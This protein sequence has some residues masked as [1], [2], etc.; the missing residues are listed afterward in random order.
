MTSS[1]WYPRKDGNYSSWLP[2][3]NEKIDQY[4]KTPGSFENGVSV[5][6]NGA[7]K[8]LFGRL[9]SQSGVDSLTRAIETH[10]LPEYF[11]GKVGM[12]CYLVISLIAFI[13]S[14]VL[15]CSLFKCFRDKFLKCGGACN[16][17]PRYHPRHFAVKLKALK[18]T[19]ICVFC[20]MFA[21]SVVSLF[22]AANLSYGTN[23][24][25]CDF[26]SGM[27]GHYFG[28]R[29]FQAP[30]GVST[31]W[32]GSNPQWVVMNQL[33]HIV[34]PKPEGARPLQFVPDDDKAT[35]TLPV[36]PLCQ[37]IIHEF[38]GTGGFVEAVDNNRKTVMKQSIEGA[39]LDE[40]MAWF[41]KSYQWPKLD[42]KNTVEF[43]F[44]RVEEMKFQYGSILPALLKKYAVDLDAT[45]DRG[46]GL[47][48]KH[49]DIYLGRDSMMLSASYETADN[50]V[51]SLG[52]VD[53]V[54]AKVIMMWDASVWPMIRVAFKIII[55]ITCVLG[56]LAVFFS[57]AGT[58]AFLKLSKDVHSSSIP[59]SK[60]ITGLGVTYVILLIFSGFS[61][62]MSS[63]LLFAG[64]A[65]SDGCGFVDTVAF[66]EGNW[67]VFPA[68]VWNE[69]ITGLT[70]IPTVLDT[71]VKRTGDGDVA[72]SL[73]LRMSLDKLEQAVDTLQAK[74]LSTVNKEL[75]LEF[76][77]LKTHSLADMTKT[78]GI[79]V[80]PE[81]PLITVHESISG[82]P[83][84]KQQLATVS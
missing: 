30:A 50:S 15:A 13:L 6:S 47:F 23:S 69:T 4:C 62:F 8:S 70:D 46:I 38:N 56:I 78:F 17:R 79:L 83:M 68:S 14:I 48:E 40:A 36:C 42:S 58:T 74:L 73:G 5:F 18:I 29:D 57:I 37:Q 41:I 71:C 61:F 19:A 35:A 75:D 84:R 28:A 45:T 51:V 49:L 26:W 31:D 60:I 76:K 32:K 7:S 80:H 2:V 66:D 59:S 27:R 20:I 39:F 53:S 77:N 44:S 10:S 65:G 9:Y 22:Y 64:S 52:D 25:A 63:I 24:L 81:R 16:D 21:V 54:M 72:A 12:I 67:K 1:G 82:Y 55:A 43:K 11:G 3:F 34:N 33:K